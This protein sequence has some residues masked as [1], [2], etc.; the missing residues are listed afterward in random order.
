MAVSLIDATSGA[1]ISSSDYNAN[2]TALESAINSF[3][4]A[5]I[6]NNTVTNDALENNSY[7][8]DVRI[9]LSGSTTGTGDIL[10]ATPVPYDSGGGTDYTIEAIEVFAADDA[11]STACTID[12]CFGVLSGT[13]ASPTESS[14]TVIKN[15]QGSLGTSS[16][17]THNKVSSFTTT[18]TQDATT[19]RLFYVRVGATVGSGGTPAM[20]PLSNVVIRLR[21][22]DGLR[23]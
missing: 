9:P 21:R 22:T 23:S 18:I 7:E 1:T 13:A 4:G 14:T 19:S 6:Q 17:Y 11:T 15:E 8:F 3:D 12:I 10:G 2:N 16:S 5:G 20:S